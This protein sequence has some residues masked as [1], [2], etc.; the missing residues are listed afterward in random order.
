MFLALIG[1]LAQV[2]LATLMLTLL[3]LPATA[4]AQIPP[5]SPTEHLLAAS[6][7]IRRGG[8]RIDGGRFDPASVGDTA[9]DVVDAIAARTPIPTPT[10]SFVQREVDG[11]VETAGLTDV[12]FLGL[13]AEDWVNIG[14][15]VLYFVLGYWL[16]VRI[17]NRLLLRLVKRTA[18]Q[19]D[20]DLLKRIDGDL[21]AMV[22]LFI[23]RYSILRLDFLSNGLRTIV[24]DA[25]FVFGLLVAVRLA[26]KL[27]DF[28]LDWYETYLHPDKKDM[29][30]PATVMLKH[31][32]KLLVY[33]A[34]ISIGLS[35]FGLANNA[36]SILL[37]AIGVIV[38]LSIKD[39]IT[40]VI[41]G[42]IIL[43][44]QPFRQGDVIHIASMA[45]EEWGWVT[46]IGSRDTRIRTRD[47][48]MLVVPMPPWGPTRSQTTHSPIHPIGCRPICGYPMDPMPI[49]CRRVLEQ[50]T[51]GV[52]GVLPDKPVEVLYLQFGAFGTHHARALVDRHL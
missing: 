39:I 40:D 31:A 32:G 9:D 46:E 33:V 34:G 27:I 44:G 21:K 5:P 35:H 37:V 38:L 45:P 12:S 30:D 20:D 50:A 28:G 13:S 42:F 16:V 1:R 47:N 19:F 22:G 25:F 4:F 15:S 29:L 26:V 36:I 8:C 18:T 6:R 11:L 43:V 7:V 52:D 48:R 3:L 41:Y 2:F 49:R 17:L 14:L 51:R 23:L 24:N 10:P